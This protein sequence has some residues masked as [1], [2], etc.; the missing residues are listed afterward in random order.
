M[1]ICVGLRSVTA[2]KVTRRGSAYIVPVPARVL[3]GTAALPVQLRFVLSVVWKRLFHRRRYPLLVLSAGRNGFF[4]TIH[5]LER[6]KMTKAI[7]V[8]SRYHFS[9]LEP[10]WPSQPYEHMIARGGLNLGAAG[11]PLKR[12]IDLA[13]LAVTRVCSYGCAH[14]YERFN[15][16]REEAIPAARW[17]GVIREL[18]GVGVS[19]VALSGGEPLDA[20]DRTLGLL[21][22]AD[23]ERSDFHLFTAGA[24]ATPERVR[25]LVDAG[26]AA[27]AVGLDDF[28]AGRHDRLR[29]RAGAHDAALRA[30]DLFG[31]AGIL[32]YANVCLRS[33]LVRDGGLWQLLELLR[34]RG[35]AA[36]QLLE[37][38]ACG[39]FAS[40]V[41]SLLGPGDRDVVSAFFEQTHRDRRCG[42]HPVVYYPAHAERGDNLGCLMGGLS[43]LYVDSLG[44]VEPCVFVPVAFGNVT[45]ESFGDILLRMRAATPRPVRGRCPSLQLSES[46][47]FQPAQRLPIPYRQVEPQWRRLYS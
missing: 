43:H 39:G 32:T 25:A 6:V 30:I 27:A 15:L 8:G 41:S 2:V 45:Q 19:V 16:G 44:N 34:G 5:L 17:S 3:S 1:A 21:E 36:M 12:Q 9:L 37:P 47:G 18:Q 22:A 38:R 35:V 29:G 7:Q 42:A 10:R 23:K 4:K 33:E 28:D 13:I 46:V 26:L 24:G 31:A 11:T 40:G 20:F 14:C